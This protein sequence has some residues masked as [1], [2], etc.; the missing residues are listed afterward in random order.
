MKNLIIILLS[1]CLYTTNVIA[2]NTQGDVSKIQMNIINLMVLGDFNL[3]YEK[4]ISKS[5]S[6]IGIIHYIPESEREKQNTY[7]YPS[8]SIN[9]GLRSY[10]TTNFFE[11]FTPNPSTEKGFGAYIEFLGGI[12]K[13]EGNY[14]GSG[15]LWLGISQPINE[16]L[17]IDYGIGITRYLGNSTLYDDLSNQKD[18]VPGV[19]LSIGIKL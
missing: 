6:T 10:I 13:V 9:Y 16:S 17:F 15:I 11:L 2:N 19:K 12:N 14:F 3:A 8:I 4:T 18:V 5:L 7:R 1:L